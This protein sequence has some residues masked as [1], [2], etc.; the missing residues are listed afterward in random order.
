MIKRG[1]TIALFLLCAGWY[2]VQATF[3]VVLVDSETGEIGLATITCVANIDLLAVL[4]VIAVEKGAAAIQAAGDFDGSRRPI[5]FDGLQ[6]GVDPVTILADAAQIS[7]HEFR[8]YGIVDIQE[9]AITFTGSTTQAQLPWAGGVTGRIGNIT[10]AVQGNVLAG[11]CVLMALEDAVLN[12]KG[13]MPELLMVAMQAAK[14]AGGDGR[15]SCTGPTAESCGCPPN[16]LGKSG[17]IGGIIVARPGDTDDANC[18]MDGCADGD[19]FMRLNVANQP[20]NAPEPADQLQALFDN[21]RQSQNGRPDAARSTVN[22][23]PPQVPPNGI[24]TQVMRIELKDWAGN[25]VAS[26]GL[27]FDVQHAAGSDQRG[28]ISDLMVLPNGILEATI[29]SGTMAGMDQF[30]IVV[31]DGIRPVQLMPRPA[32]TYPRLGDQNLDDQINIT[33]F[34]LIA[35]ATGPCPGP[36]CIADINGDGTVDLQDILALAPNWD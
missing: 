30:E 21:F 23:F 9:R 1:F 5:V 15:C 28:Q 33:D 25:A 16:P 3:S 19:Y 22:F 26:D 6:M 29:T 24:N 27:S 10:Y 4:P 14:D 36:I 17:H 2:Q 7:G 32:N 35:T 20:A 18:N 8:Q 34:V 13:D 11:E 12:T 31:N